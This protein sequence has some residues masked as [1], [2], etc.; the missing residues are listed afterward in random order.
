VGSYLSV[1]EGPISI[2]PHLRPAVLAEGMVV[3]NEPGFYLPGAYGIRLENLELIREAD[4]GTGKPFY[5]FETLTLAPF[6]RTLIEPGLLRADEVAWL[7][8]YHAR[9]LRELGPKLPAD[10]VSW[11]AQACAK[12]EQAA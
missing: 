6:D 9:V 12:L 11:L 8:N 3:S 5:R 1:H 10:V 4:L 7:D 2:S